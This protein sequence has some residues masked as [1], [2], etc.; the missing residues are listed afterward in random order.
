MVL[1]VSRNLFVED[2][3]SRH[4]PVAILAVH[5][6]VQLEHPPTAFIH[7]EDIPVLLTVIQGERVVFYPP[8]PFSRHLGHDDTVLDLSKAVCPSCLWM[9]PFR[10]QEPRS[11]TWLRHMRASMTATINSIEDSSNCW[12]I[13]SIS[14]WQTHRYHTGISSSSGTTQHQER[15]I[16]R[17]TNCYR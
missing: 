13:T 17:N 5:C 14:V 4:V 8:Q 12:P 16:N 9:L 1:F 15:Y 3:N 6:F 10:K 2:N 11:D 7:L